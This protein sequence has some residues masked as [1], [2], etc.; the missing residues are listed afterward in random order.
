V[1]GLKVEGL[2]PGPCRLLL[3]LLTFLEYNSPNRIFGVNF[4]PKCFLQCFLTYKEF[5]KNCETLWITKK[6]LI[7][8]CSGPVKFNF[9]YNSRQTA[10]GKKL[11]G[12]LSQF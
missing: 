1:R 12:I 7:G 3:L 6:F 8:Q 9:G 11:S 5:R 10:L 2:L 4:F